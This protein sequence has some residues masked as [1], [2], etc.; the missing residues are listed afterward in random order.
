MFCG[1]TTDTDSFT[2]FL[3][4]MTDFAPLAR[5]VTLCLFV[6]FNVTEGKKHLKMRKSMFLIVMSNSVLSPAHLC[7]AFLLFQP[8]AVF[9]F[10]WKSSKYQTPDKGSSYLVNIVEHLAVKELDLSLRTL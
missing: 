2:G 4:D 7:R 10:V 5:S 9:S 6:W 1:K 8:A 3:T